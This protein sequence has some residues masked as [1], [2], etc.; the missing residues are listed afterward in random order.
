MPCFCLLIWIDTNV[1]SFPVSFP[2]DSDELVRS[3]ESFFAFIQSLCVKIANRRSQSSQ[4]VLNPSLG[5]VLRD[6]RTNE[7]LEHE[8]DKNRDVVLV[9]LDVEHQ[10]GDDTAEVKG[11]KKTT[12]SSV[13]LFVKFSCG[14]NF[15]LVLQGFRAACEWGLQ[16]E[17]DFYEGIAPCGILPCPTSV[18]LSGNFATNRLCLVLD[19]VEGVV[20]P[21]F[22]GAT[23]EQAISVLVTVARMHGAF[24]GMN[25]SGAGADTH[26]GALAAVA[27][28]KLICGDS[29]QPEMELADGIVAC[30]DK[31]NA[32]LGLEY[33]SFIRPM[34]DK[35]TEP[36]EFLQ[37]WDAIDLWITSNAIT[38][39]LVHG[40]CRLGNMIFVKE[41]K[42]LFS[43]FEAINIAPF[44]WDFVYFT[45]LCQ[46]PTDR[47]NRHSK[48]L[49]S[50]L[51]ALDK[52]IFF[53][54]KLR[55]PS[56]SVDREANCELLYKILTLV[57]FFYAYTVERSGAWV[58]NGNT[59]EDHRHWK[60]RVDA[61]IQELNVEEICNALGCKSSL[62]NRVKAVELGQTVENSR[63]KKTK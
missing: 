15:P 18:A 11:P 25:V 22:R 41:S 13:R 5:G 9:E 45:I 29:H 40:D 21:D 38:T 56:V 43:D 31:I 48:L 12:T 20:T 14:R 59:D 6:M 8:P 26:I 19:Y 57:L 23:L 47:Q 2:R 60:V 44:L 58:D 52:Q 24:W 55:K 51:E 1:I 33:F 10:H 53:V 32:R 28:G 36:P 7:P 42:V 50:Y 27:A 34:L 63:L 61:A 49:A 17:L 37:L 39:T 16:R 30:L 4:R 62:V 3:P 54:E 46:S 35:S